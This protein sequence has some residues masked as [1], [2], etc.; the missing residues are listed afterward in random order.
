VRDVG[1]MARKRCWH[2]F[3]RVGFCAVAF[4][5]LTGCGSSGEKLTPVAGKVTVNGASLGTGS[6][7]FHP[8]TAKG[9][10]TPHIPVG[11]LD[12]QGNY[13]LMTATQEGAPLGWYQITVSAQEPIDPKNPYAPPKHLINP[14]YS[15]L[16]TSGLAVEVVPSPAPR[17]YDLKLAK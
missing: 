10:S 12:A 4:A 13:K 6:V 8:D 9:N 3:S 2:F 15:D 14:K 16:G 1:S 7:T 5:A 17:A 11:T